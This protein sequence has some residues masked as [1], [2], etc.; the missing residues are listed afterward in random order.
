MSNLSSA[1][2][3]NLKGL[4]WAYFW[5]L[6]FEGALRKWIVPQLSA[7]LLIIR[8]PI[9][10]LI[11]AQA[12]SCGLFPK[13]KWV[14]W[15]IVLGVLSLLASLTGE[16]TMKVTLY[17]LRCNFLHLPLIFVIPEIFDYEDAKKVGK[18]VLLVSLPMA[19]L[20][21]LQFRAPG[22]AWI[23]AAAGG[24]AVGDPSGQLETAMGKIRPPGVFSFVTGMV[25]F[26][27]LATAFLAHDVADRKV[28]P[29]WL[30][31]SA[32]AALVVSV[33]VS[34]SRSAV[35]GAVI[36]GVVLLY[37]A[38]RRGIVSMRYVQYIAGMIVIYMVLQHV[39]VFKEG[40]EVH[41]ER[42]EAG[43]GIHEGLIDRFFNELITS[44]SACYVTPFLGMG[45][46]LG[47]NAGAGLVSGSR[48]FLLSEGEWGRV[49]MESGPILGISYIVLRFGIFFDLLAASFRSMKRGNSLPLLLL[50]ATGIDLLTGQFGQP[51]ELG[52]VVFTSG[53]CLVTYKREMARPAPVR[54]VSSVQL[55]KI[56][57][58]SI[59]AEALH[60]GDGG[61][62]A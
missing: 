35:V 31:Y 54:P 55:K 4:V 33:A 13:N 57:G 15:T 16:G 60:G 20:V 2:L 32:M 14:M 6:I 11:Y 30:I 38:F 9:V 40:I 8:D 37:I 22:D 17:G 23:N 48:Q 10:L 28:Y 49:I 42:F 51:T 24:G 53:L 50:S 45:L 7:P 39:P 41:K 34:G 46:G 52:F 21:Y 36:V 44:F 3:R 26:T 1:A 47:T 12:S 56:R 59:Y 29:R 58:R 19:A 43:G 61:G 5:L 27:T 18:M 62:A 25:S